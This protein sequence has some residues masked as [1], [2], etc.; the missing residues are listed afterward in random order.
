MLQGLNRRSQNVPAAARSAPY[1]LST[2]GITVDFWDLTRLL[3]RR[4]Y[5]AVP[6]L[7]ISVIG[8][9]LAGTSVQPDYSGKGYLL[10]IPPHPTV[11]TGTTA[12]PARA[13][14]PWSDLGGWA[15][16][17]AAVLKVA[18]GNIRAD[19]VRRGLSENYT[20]SISEGSAMVNIEGVGSSPAQATATIRE[21]LRLLNQVIKD[22]QNQF[23]VE[24]Q[25]LFTTLT[26]ADGSD[27]DVV[28]SKVKR[29]AIVAG[30]VGLLLTAATTLGLDS[31]L[32]RRSR[33]SGGLPPDGVPRSRDYPSPPPPMPQ[34][35]SY[36]VSPAGPQPPPA[37]V[38]VGASPTLAAGTSWPSRPAISD[39][40]ASPA[41]ERAA[42]DQGG[43]PDQSTG[44]DGSPQR[45]GAPDETIVLPLSY[46]LRGR[47]QDNRN[48][49]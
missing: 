25:D 36:P 6:M 26:L 41:D 37:L 7:L 8:V 34:P 30:G 23:G 32:R 22:Q 28:T 20:V 3:L 38:E 10:L 43:R 19:M 47:A 1:T 4:W 29:I 44:A 35:E 16:G 27:V 48:G 24:T 21:V 13:H 45:S 31:F 40:S 17:N 9:F 5:I 46:A 39:S 49:R 42:L 2:Q 33:R 11:T 18:S 12:A 15:L 14:N